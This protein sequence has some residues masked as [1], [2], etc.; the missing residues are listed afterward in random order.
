[1]NLFRFSAVRRSR[2]HYGLLAGL[3]GDPADEMVTLLLAGR[4]ARR[5]RAR[6]DLV[7]DQQFRTLLDKNIAA[8]LGFYEINANDLIGIVVVNAGVALDL[9]V[10]AGLRVGANNYGF[11]VKLVAEFVLPLLA[12]MRQTD[13]GEAFDLSA[14][15][16]LPDDQESFDCFADANV[17]G[18]QQPDR[19]LP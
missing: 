4:G 7:N 8:V 12:K 6:V 13:H 1:M 5:S 18:D 9:P 2:E 11:E 19:L 10:E 17:V 15:K 3:L 16:K 14:L